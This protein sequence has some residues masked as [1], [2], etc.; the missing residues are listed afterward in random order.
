MSWTRKILADR[1][2]GGKQVWVNETN[3]PVWGDPTP[4]KREPGSH[5]AT[6]DEQAAFILQAYAYA[7]AAGAGWRGAARP[8]LSRRRA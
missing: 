8:A 5:R 2:M 4:T 6:P 3:I 1:R 7:F